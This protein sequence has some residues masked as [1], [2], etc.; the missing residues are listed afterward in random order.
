MYA[1]STHKREDIR[2][3]DK[4]CWKLYAKCNSN[5]L[6]D[7]AL[8]WERRNLHIPLRKII[9]LVTEHVAQLVEYWTAL[10]LEFTFYCISRLRS[11]TFRP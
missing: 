10:R 11:R 1:V 8:G 2:L 3:R 5:S 6:H 4:C 9:R 7:L